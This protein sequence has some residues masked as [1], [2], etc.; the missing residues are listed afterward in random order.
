MSD[1]ILFLVKV[2]H[3][4]IKKFRLKTA[5]ACRKWSETWTH[6]YVQRLFA[7]NE[8][9]TKT[10]LRN[11]FSSLWVTRVVCKVTGYVLYSWNMIQVCLYVQMSSK[12]TEALKEI[13]VW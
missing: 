6:K 10:S 3:S 11:A 13:R 4:Q 7:D 12:P 1:Q 5:L 2:F 8:G 9:A